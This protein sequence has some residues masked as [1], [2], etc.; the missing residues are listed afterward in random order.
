[1]RTAIVVSGGDAPGINAAV[2]SFS[3][4]AA[5]EGDQVLGAEDGIAGL[6][7]GRLGEIDRAMLTRLAGRGGRYYAQ[8]VNPCWARRERARGW[9][10]R[11]AKMR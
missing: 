9:A 4:L 6:L 11:C 5:L 10:R 7:A 8:A 3:R 1:M 2:E